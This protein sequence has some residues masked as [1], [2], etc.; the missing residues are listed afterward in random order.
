MASSKKR[1][2][3]ETGVIAKTSN[4]P[5]GELYDKW[6]KKSRKEIGTIAMDE[7]DRGDDH[8]HSRPSPNVKV[9]RHVKDE[10]RSHQ[11][12][13][14]LHKQK[15]E[16]AMKNMRKDKRTSIE[17]ANRKKKKAQQTAKTQNYST[18]A[19]NRRS[20]VLIRN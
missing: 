4:R 9:N 11:E 16:M 7:D 2:R 15:S 10:V 8:R 13:K 17:N 20:K 6:K 12:L 5:Q 14:K 19:R 3:T 18:S 1:I